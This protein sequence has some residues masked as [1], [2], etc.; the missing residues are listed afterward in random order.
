MRRAQLFTAFSLALLVAM[1]VLT[2]S[3]ETEPHRATTR[4]EVP[5]WNLEARMAEGRREREAQAREADAKRQRE[6]AIEMARI[7]RSDRLAGSM[8]AFGS[9]R[10]PGLKGSGLRRYQSHLRSLAP[11]FTRVAES[12]ERAF[13][14]PETDAYLLAAIA[15]HESSWAQT[16]I[17]GQR[18]G[19]RG[20]VGMM[21]IMPG[22]SCA[23]GSD[24][25][26]R[27][28]DP[29]DAVDNLRLAVL[30]LDRIREAHA[31]RRSDVWGWL[32]TY[33][34]GQI[35]GGRSAVEGPRG[36]RA[37]FQEMIDHGQ[38]LGNAATGR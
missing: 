21:Q 1:T 23:F 4:R 30:C 17:T 34:S 5:A 6:V 35:G 15:Y 36:F 19:L 25:D 8:A 27:R 20:E 10:I 16:V 32:G 26:G 24:S 29:L 38:R 33:A 18:R 2:A 7:E 3:S 14:S 31:G 22:G 11:L 37:I 13:I 9:K 28:L 12:R